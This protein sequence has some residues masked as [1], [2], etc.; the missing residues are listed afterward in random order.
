GTFVSRVQAPVVSSLQDGM[1]PGTTYSFGISAVDMADNESPQTFGAVTTL[2]CPTCT[3]WLTQVSTNPTWWELRPRLTV[4]SP[5]TRME[6]SF[7]TPGILVMARLD[8]G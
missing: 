8:P 7:R 6:R 3:L 1:S 2:T 4:P 5:A